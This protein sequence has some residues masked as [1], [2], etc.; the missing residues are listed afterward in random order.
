MNTKLKTIFILNLLFSINCYGLKVQSIENTIIHI[1]ENTPYRFSLPNDLIWAIDKSD[2]EQ[3][4]KLGSN[5]SQIELEAAINSPIQIVVSHNKQNIPLYLAPI[6]FAC[7]KGNFD[8]V[9]LLIKLGGN[10]NEEIAQTYPFM[11][12][13]TLF[14]IILRNVYFYGIETNEEDVLKIID[15]LF[16]Q[17][18]KN[19]YLRDRFKTTP[20]KACIFYLPISDLKI[21]IAEKLAPHSSTEELNE[22]LDIVRTQQADEIEESDI[23][24]LDTLYGIIL[25]G[26]V[27]KNINLPNYLCTTFSENVITELK[28]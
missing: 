12:G 28:K 5:H 13:N 19:N 3:I 17:S 25:N 14:T 15:L 11:G 20:L 7:L 22:M 2:L 16:E 1:D 4:A 18:I 9:R 24:L 26:L 10:V 8:I 27:T 21:K 6:H 23:K